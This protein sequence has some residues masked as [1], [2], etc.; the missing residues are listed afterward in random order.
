MKKALPKLGSDEPLKTQGWDHKIDLKK[1]KAQNKG[2]TE[3]LE[4]C[5]IP[6]EGRHHSGIDDARN[7]SKIVQYAL[8]HGFEF[9]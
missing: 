7:L 4:A 9:N 5:K 8:G 2:M 6:L 1:V 3:M